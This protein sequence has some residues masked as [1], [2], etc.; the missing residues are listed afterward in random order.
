MTPAE[1]RL[2]YGDCLDWMEEWLP[3]A[4]ES[5]DLIYLDPPFNSNTDY[6]ILFGAGN[7]V[8]AQVRGFRDTWKWDDTAAERV[9]RIMRATSHPIHDVTRGFQAMIPR[10]GMLAYLTYMGERLALMRELLAP[11]GNLYLH[12]DDTA[13]HYLRAL[14]DAIFGPGRY[15]SHIAWRRANAHND[16]RRFGRILDHILHYA[17]G[18]QP[19]WDGDVSAVS[20]TAA[21]LARAYP[22]ED[23][24]G[25]YRSDNLT[26]PAHG[27]EKGSPST[28]PWRNYDVHA[29]GRVWSVPKTG[30]Y[31]AFIE[32]EFI[33]GY[34]DIEGVH[35]RLDALDEAG[36][37]HHPR[38]GFWPG[39]KRYAAADRGNLPQNLIL[40]PRGFTNY[41]AQGGE[42]LGFDTQKPVALL[43]QL[44][45]PA[46]PP[47][48]LVLDPFCGCGSSIVAAHNLGRRWLGI[49]I[50]ATA[51]DIIRERRLVPLG[52]EAPAEGIPYDL[53]AARKLAADKPLD[54]E[55]WA[56]TRVPGLAPNE[57]KGADAGIDGRGRLLDKPDNHDST[58]VLAQVKG[59]SF[60]LSELRDFLHVVERE[61]AACGVY[62]TCD[63]VTSAQAR[64]EVRQQGELHVGA[65]RYP[66]VQLW[67]AEELF[68]GRMP[69]MPTVADPNTGRAIQPRLRQVD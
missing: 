31:A 2:Y 18:D 44:I 26:G 43:E 12:C 62:I 54:F 10:S 6:N 14:L 20:K 24:V 68:E 66:R 38:T 7:G 22:S 15:R 57:R 34:R 41:S 61:G 53:R 1:N 36:L 63:R 64:A 32:G 28:L 50:S 46:C 52:I 19:F 49:D 9:A 67:S 39:L 51:I 48:G 27:A 17:K 69:T 59:G 4:R 45:A 60:R 5:V 3:E 37:I 16:P 33:P 65:G 25:R 56:V 13:S 11:T 29:R 55:A 23:E 40:E 35:D 47:D 21:E 58:L 42:Y 30:S 8:S